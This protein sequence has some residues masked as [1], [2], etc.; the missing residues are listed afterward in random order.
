MADVLLGLDVLKENNFCQVSGRTVGL[1]I[2]AASVNSSFISTVNL[3]QTAEKV[4]LAALFGPQHG[5]WGETQDNM[6]EWDGFRDKRT[7]LP[8]YSLYG[9]T[10]EPQP[11]MLADIDCLVIDLSDVGARY[12]TFVWTMVLCLRACKVHGIS[13]IILDRPNPLTGIATEGPLLE[14]DFSS[15]VG[16][17]PLPTRHGMTMAEL[18]QY[19]NHKYRIDCE[20]TVIPMKGWQREMWYD[21]TGLPWI[22][23]S[24]NM[25]TLD[26]AIVYPGTALIEGTTVSEG[27]GTTK[28]FEIIGA[29]GI[30]PYDLAETLNYEQLPGVTF[31][32]L[33]FIPTFQK[34]QG[35]LCGGVQI[36]VTERD[37]FLPVLTGVAVIRTIYDLYPEILTWRNPPYEYEKERLPIDILSGTDTV[38]IQIEKRC[39]LEDISQSWKKNNDLFLAERSPYLLY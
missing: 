39:S 34:H 16:L 24:P 33:S 38:R 22:L 7:G 11:E 26:T 9:K 4:T 31:R 25:P 5:L 3:F 27:R 37:V 30:N 35:R 14:P 13:C 36:H 32:P 6:V 1:V 12:Y 10:R 18:A 2:N 20:L 19:F 17:Y 8:V 23:P 29:P 28:P 15:F 21:Q